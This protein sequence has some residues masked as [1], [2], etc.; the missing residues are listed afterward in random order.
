MGTQK[1]KCRALALGLSGALVASIAAVGSIPASA[2]EEAA[3][4]PATQQYRPYL[5]YTPEKNWMN[6]PNGLVYHK[7]VYHMFYQHNPF[8][9][10][11]GN[12]SWGH[13]TSTDLL[14]WTEQPLAIPQTL[15]EDGVSVED[16]F[17]GSVVVDQDNSSGF[18]TEEDPAL[19]AVYTS[20]YTGAHP[21]LA[22][23]QAQ[24]LAY[25]TDDGQ[26]WTKYEGNPVLDRDSANFRDPKVF[27]YDGPAGSYWV[28]VAVEATDHKVV[29]YKSDN[30]KDWTHLSDFGPANSV[31]GIWECPDLFPI[32]VDGD[33]NNIKWVM[34]VNLNP[35]AVAG[36]SGGQYFVGDFDG[37]TFTSETTVPV[38]EDTLPEGTLFE[39]FNDGTWNGWTA[40]NE[41]GNDQSGPW[42][43]APTTGTLPGQMTVSDFSGA[44]FVNGFN[45]HDGPTGTLESPTFTVG[46]EDYINFLVGGGNHPA[47]PGGQSENNPPAGELLFDGF[48]Y[49]QG[50]LDDEGWTLTGDLE[51]ARNP[52]TVGGEYYIGTGRI[53]TFEG[54]PKGDGN[55]GT[56]TSPAFTINDTYLS[57]LIGGGGRTD[58]TL[59]AELLVN[60]EVVETATGTNEGALNWQHWDV[61]AYAGQEAVLRIVDNATGGWG[62]ITLDHVV[63][64]PEPAQVRS[65]ETTV[66]LV[67]DGEVV[68]STTG[69]NTE[70]LDW[71]NWD[72]REFEGQQASIKLVDNNRGGW[73]HLLADEFMFSNT[74]AQNFSQLEEYDWLD[75]GKDYY[76]TV[77]FS[78]APDNKRIMLG[79]MSNWDY[80]NDTPTSTWRSSMALPREV[81]LTET[82]DGPR[83][84]QKVVDQI[85][86]IRKDYAAFTDKPRTIAEGTETLPITGDVVQI[87]AEF[88]PGDAEQFG[89][90]VLG[91]GTEAAKIGYD[92]ST[93]RLFS[94]RTNSG[95]EGFHPAFSSINDAPV[96]LE[97]GRIALRVYVDRASVEIF[98]NGGLT[99][100]TDQVF[101]NAGANQIGLFSEGG[102]AKLESLTVT[103]LR[104][105]MWDNPLPNDNAAAEP[106]KAKLSI[107]R[108][109]APQD[110][111]YALNMELTK[112][113]NAAVFEL[114]ENGKLIKTGTLAP[115]KPGKQTA[116]VAISDQ[117]DGKYVYTGVLVNTKGHTETTK[118]T[119]VVKNR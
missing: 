68:R 54:G 48:E 5:H 61:S 66:N 100:I 34:V 109:K 79:W 82:P 46:G 37:T 8:G 76:A 92:T 67:V 85:D 43:E 23:K 22:G 42:G 62:A 80:A 118:Q 86:T 41:P 50:T 14:R 32:A 17:S 63:M 77:S 6:D 74:P 94:D 75:W 60:G 116:S 112:G 27:R 64:G 18:G 25:S 90:T 49:P 16:I 21:T 51:E 55:L 53:N 108:G 103:P 71:T 101:P 93:G 29:L 9:T 45:G 113:E 102:E 30:L 38:P 78:N 56:L 83:L 106:A 65:S 3:V 114:Y 69:D 89:L 36:G 91:D 57:F 11:W 26:T 10:Q 88:S 107:D 117:E 98:A 59:Q 73:G 99:T 4:D 39:G 12:M 87:D 31:E 47:I 58:G 70:S 44:G 52:S 24:S 81:S 35:G 15:N 40:N 28:M 104:A 13:A 105:T 96:P 1:L 2:E 19:V 33:P 119:I 115:S 95:N 97:N 111:N 110:G 7:G 72:V 84:V 20:A